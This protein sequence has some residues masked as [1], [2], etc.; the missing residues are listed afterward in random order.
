MKYPSFVPKSFR[1]L[2]PNEKATTLALGGIAI[3]SMIYFFTRK[4]ATSPKAP[5]SRISVQGVWTD[6]ATKLG[7]PIGDGMDTKTAQHYLNVISHAKLAE[8]GVLGSATQAALRKFQQGNGLPQSGVIDEETGNALQYLSAASSKN[9]LVQKQATATSATIQSLGKGYWHDLVAQLPKLGAPFT[10]T[11]KMSTKGAKRALNDIMHA[12]LPLDSVLDSH[13]LAQIRNFQGEQGLPVTG[14]LDPETSNAL[15][16]TASFVNPSM[17]SKAVSYTPTPMP[18]PVTYSPSPMPNQYGAPPTPTQAQ[19]AQLAQGMS[20]DLGSGWVMYGNCAC[21]AN[22]AACIASC[23]A[24]FGGTTQ[25]TGE[26]FVGAQSTTMYDP[27]FH[28]GF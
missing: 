8:D 26:A 7:M 10:D 20:V 6:L 16:Y 1:R 2:S 15:L 28:Y 3:G 27:R 5:A 13:T 14:R 11:V 24:P 18:Q 22:D 25:T 17:R 12:G 23:S 9:P 21:Q 19:Q 4:A